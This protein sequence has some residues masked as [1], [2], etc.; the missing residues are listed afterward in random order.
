M[1]EKGKQARFLLFK[2]SRDFLLFDDLLSKTVILRD[3]YTGRSNEV[4]D[5]LGNL[6]KRK[7]ERRS[8][9]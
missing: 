8:S 9:D 1:K 5:F 3:N 2:T 4:H 7:S 6:P